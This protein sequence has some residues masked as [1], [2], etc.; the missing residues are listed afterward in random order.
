MVPEEFTTFRCAREH[1]GTKV[2]KLCKMYKAPLLG[3]KN[4]DCYACTEGF[5][6][7]PGQGGVCIGVCPRWFYL[8]QV[9][10]NDKGYLH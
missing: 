2:D 4:K 9:R 5:V 7:T 3:Y 6:K 10:H 8:I 1:K